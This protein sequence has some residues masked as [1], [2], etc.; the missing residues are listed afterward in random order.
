MRGALVALL[1]LEPDIRVMAEVGSGN[2]V[3]AAA[4]ACRPD[5]ALLDGGLPRLDGFTAS[6]E[7]KRQL[8]ECRVVLLT[9]FE[10]EDT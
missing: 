7:I 10:R 3:V 2:E 9:T 6:A 1:H 4:L 5:I 8:Q